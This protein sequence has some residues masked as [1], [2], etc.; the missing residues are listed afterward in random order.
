MQTIVMVSTLPSSVN[1]F[2]I[3]SSFHDKVN[4]VSVLI[5]YCGN[6]KWVVTTIKDEVVRFLSL[7]FKVTAVD[8]FLSP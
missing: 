2:H 5:G 4:T 6:T 7:F 8:A 1:I 3:I